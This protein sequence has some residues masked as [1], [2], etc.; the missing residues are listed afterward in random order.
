MKTT[1]LSLRSSYF[2]GRLRPFISRAAA[3][4]ARSATCLLPAATAF[5]QQPVQVCASA[6]YTLTSV[7]AATG[8]AEITYQWYENGQPVEKA[9][10]ATLAVAAG[11]TPGIYHYVRRVSCTECSE[12]WTPSNTFTVVVNA[13]PAVPTLQSNNSR[14]DAGTVTFSA[15]A[16]EGCTIDWYN[17]AKATDIGSSTVT[18]GTTSWSPNLANTTTYY[19]EA[20]DVTTGCVSASRLAVT[21]T[22]SINT[23]TIASNG[24]NCLSDTDPLSGVLLIATAAGATSYTWY[25]DGGEEPVQSGTSRSYTVKESGTYTV[26]GINATCTGLASAGFP[27]ATHLRPDVPTSL[28]ADSRCD[29]VTFSASLPEN[30]AANCTIDWYAAAGGGSAVA[31]GTT[32]WSTVLESA[33]T[34]YAEARDVTTGCVSA[35]R[36]AVTGTVSIN[37]A[38]I[39]GAAVNTCPDATVL[40]TAT[41]AGATSYT[42]YKYGEEEQEQVQSG[43]SHSYTVTESGTYSVEGMDAACTGLASDGFPV[44]INAVPGAPTDASNNSRCD[45]GTLTFSASLPANCTDNC[46][47][48]WYTAAVGGSKVATDTTSWSTVLDSA[49]TYYAETRDETTGCVSARLAVTGARNLYEGEI[50]VVSD[51]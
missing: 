13:V 22:V 30:C 26:E 36:L 50:I 37:T 33:T 14:C 6:N 11:K 21:G 42:W 44:T 20:R 1:L 41:A 48:D 9:N 17:V 8:T 19:A 31:A 12:E 25:K 3:F 29:T 47:M 15:T 18:A 38:T 39:A 4:I 24:N 34:Y 40:L 10:S 5:A 7:A 43:A 51:Y 46:T 2:I 35:S 49:T 27:V 23:A 45:A 32:S 28:S 16:P